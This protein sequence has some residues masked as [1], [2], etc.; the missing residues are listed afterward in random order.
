MNFGKTFQLSVTDPFQGLQGGVRPPHPS[1]LDNYQHNCTFRE[2]KQAKKH[3]K[4]SQV[5]C[6]NRIRSGCMAH[7]GQDLRFL[8]F[9]TAPDMKRTKEEAF[10]ALKERVRRATPL[11]MHRAVAPNGGLHGFLRHYYPD[12]PPGENLDFEYTKITTKEGPSGV[13]HVLFFGDYLPQKWLSS[14]WRDLTDTAYIVDIHR[15]TV[16]RGSEKRLATY[17][18]NQYVS[19]GQTEYVRFSN[20]WRWCFRGFMGAWESFRRE[21]SGVPYEERWARWENY[22]KTKIH[23]PPGHTNLWNYGLEELNPRFNSVGPVAL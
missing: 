21:F 22:L 18:V 17:S 1:L 12:R 19:G 3:W 10:R 20:S 6:Y 14:V 13:F 8:T 15:A 16:Q 11:S 9:T 4:P 5:R 7:R 2:K 23:P